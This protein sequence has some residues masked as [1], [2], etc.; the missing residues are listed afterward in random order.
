MADEERSRSGSAVSRRQLLGIAGAAAA[1]S[2]LLGGIRV[3][4]RAKLS[5]V[6]EA[7]ELPPAA[8]GFR[9]PVLQ[10]VSLTVNGTSHNIDIDTRSTLANALREELHLTGTHVTCDRGECGACTVLVDGRAVY[11]CTALAV[12]MQGKQ[13]TT[14]EGL[15]KGEK[16]DPI[17]EAFVECDGFQCGYCTA[18]Q[19][20][21]L[22]ALLLKNPSPT[23]DDVRV[24]VSGNICRCGAYPGIIKAGLVAAAKMRGQGG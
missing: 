9:K 4:R 24:A 3:R 12:Q 21:S 16:L 15:A 23:E 8:V 13:I 20:M 1:A 6:A 2:G 19:M 10:T 18:G 5:G 22:K 7:A 11:A 17:Q 14:V